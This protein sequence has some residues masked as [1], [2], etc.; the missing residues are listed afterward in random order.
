VTPQGSGL[1]GPG[2]SL[3]CSKGDSFCVCRTCGVW[4]EKSKVGMIGSFPY[5]G[6]RDAV[7]KKSG[8]LIRSWRKCVTN[9]DVRD[10]SA[11]FTAA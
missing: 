7:N 3:C 2:G 5:A 9:G 11:G 8:L 10:E 4:I 6:T 1:R